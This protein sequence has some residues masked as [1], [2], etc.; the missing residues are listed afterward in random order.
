MLCGGTAASTSVAALFAGAGSVTPVGRAALAVF[1]TDSGALA[2][3]VAGT[4]NVPVPPTNRLIG[5]E[6]LPAPPLTHDEPA[7]ATHVQLPNVSPAG[8]VSV[9]VAPVTASGPRLVTVIV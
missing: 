8:A 1:T 2:A 7:V 4:E 3:T 5:V 6:R 9:N